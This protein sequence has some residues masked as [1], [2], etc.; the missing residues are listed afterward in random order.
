MLL[1][2]SGIPVHVAGLAAPFPRAQILGIIGLKLDQR[3][4]RIVGSVEILVEEI[5]QLRR[6]RPQ[7]GVAHNTGCPGQ[8]DITGIA[9]L[10]QGNADFHPFIA[11]YLANF[12]IP[13]E[14]RHKIVV[15]MKEQDYWAHMGLLFVH[16]GQIHIL[17]LSDPGLDLLL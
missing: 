2:L 13:A 5:A 1:I 6:L 17:V 14:G 4:I 12:G 3:V 11:S 7:R 10:M 15:V 16:R 8:P 9:V